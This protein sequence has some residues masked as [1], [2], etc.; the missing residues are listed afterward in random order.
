MDFYCRWCGYQLFW[1]LTGGSGSRWRRVLW[2]LW[3][4]YLLRHTRG[5]R[6]KPRGQALVIKDLK[7]ITE[8]IFSAP[9]GGQASRPVSLFG[10]GATEKTTTDTLY[11]DVSVT[12][13]VMVSVSRV[14]WF[15]HLKKIPTR[16][17]KFSLQNL[18]NL[19]ITSTFQY[20]FGVLFSPYRKGV[21]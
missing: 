2:L 18:N 15:S 9:I 21:A 10:W 7:N 11:T 19:L 12:V 6:P 3:N 17:Q 4:E 1:W 16:L 14:Q 5:R 8:E 13:T 20:S